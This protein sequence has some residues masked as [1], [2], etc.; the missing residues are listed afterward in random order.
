MLSAVGWS[1]AYT[2]DDDIEWLNGLVSGLAAAGIALI[3]SAAV[4]LNSKINSTRL[5][6]VIAT[7]SAVIAFYWPKP[8][9]FPC[10]I[11][12]GGLTTIIF[13]RQDII[14][15]KQM[16]AGTDTL[17]FNK[18]GGGMLLAVWIGVLIGVLVGAGQTKYIDMKELHWFS[19]FY[20]TGSI[21]FGGGQVVLPMLYNDVVAADCPNQQSICCPTSLD[22]NQTVVDICNDISQAYSYEECK[23]SWMSASQFYAGL[24]IAQAM[25]GPLFNFS[26]Y[27]GAVIAQNAKVF[28]MIGIIV[29][30][31]GLFAPGI[32]IIFAILPFWGSFRHFQLYRRA[33]PGLNSAAVGLIITSVFQLTLDAYDSSPFPV[34][35]ICIGM[36]AFGCT[37]VLHVPAPFIVIGGGALGVVGWAAGMI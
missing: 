26:A 30:W 25:P 24:A 23:C 16:A 19:A 33:L 4:A 9:T 22:A 13:K 28:A 37:Q 14:E 21:I 35:S 12:L 29:C 1:L 2:L 3:A 11:L 10:L 20:R 36:I 34:T 7:T 27:L 31:V 32:I 15:V 17:G 6:Q 8:W 18:V 5:L